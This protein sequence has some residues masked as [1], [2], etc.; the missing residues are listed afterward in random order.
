M[1]RH[2]LFAFRGTRYAVRADAVHTVFRLPELSPAEE[3]PHYFVGL[4]DLHGEVV[5]VVDLA[6]RFGHPPEPLLTEQAVVV[7]EHLERRV[8]VVVDAVHDIVDIDAACIEPYPQLDGMPAEPPVAAGAVR[9]D[10]R[11]L[12]LLDAAT[13]M[14][15]LVERPAQAQPAGHIARHHAGLDAAALE[16]LRRRACALAEPPATDTDGGDWFA[17]AGIGDQQ[18]ALPLASVVEIAHLGTCTPLPCCPSH[19][20]GCMNLRGTILA[21]LDL[22]PLLLGHSPGDYRKVVVVRCAGRS[23]ALA[24]NA[25]TDIRAFPREAATPLTADAYGHPHCSLLLHDDTR[26]AGVLDLESLFRQG[27]L[28]VD[29]AA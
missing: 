13:L 9:A 1:I 2:L 3:L 29:D 4:A 11:V 6:Q 17:L 18:F 21:V 24:V 8:G 16:T 26:T 22:A 14:R 23:F 12:I 7:L 15:L 28:D 5:P 25:I 19:V 27:L 20:L 10:G